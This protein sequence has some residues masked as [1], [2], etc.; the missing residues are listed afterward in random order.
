MMKHSLLC[1]KAAK[2]I[3]TSIPRTEIRENGVE[4]PIQLCMERAVKHDT[5]I[6]T[7]NGNSNRLIMN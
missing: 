1:G 7:F 2:I 6:E 5:L 4:M 3:Y